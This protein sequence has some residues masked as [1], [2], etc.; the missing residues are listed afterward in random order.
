M[1]EVII[2]F[3]D[4]MLLVLVVVLLGL[5]AGNLLRRFLGDALTALRRSYKSTDHFDNGDDWKTP[6]LKAL[7]VLL[8][9]AVTAFFIGLF[10]A[11]STILFALIVLLATLFLSS[12]TRYLKILCYNLGILGVL[13]L[14][15][16]LPMLSFESWDTWIDPL[17]RLPVYLLTP[18]LAIWLVDF[19]ESSAASKSILF[20]GTS[21]L[22]A[23]F[24]P[25]IVLAILFNVSL[26]MLPDDPAANDFFKSL[27]SAV[28]RFDTHDFLEAIRSL[29][30]M[31]L[32]LAGFGLV[33]A[34]LVVFLLLWN[35]FLLNGLLLLIFFRFKPQG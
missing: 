19:E 35:L 31:H 6:L 30:S 27:E 15:R 26:A 16:M 29:T 28:D 17:L 32:M 2:A 25:I 23:V 1:R 12:S 11:Q 3:S 22:L 20:R 13:R 4:G 21:A 14:T 8:G 24:A 9:A 10:E 7:A 5:I 18:I 34:L 33:L